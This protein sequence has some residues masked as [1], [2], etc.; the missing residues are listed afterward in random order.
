MIMPGP[1]VF[2]DQYPN[3]TESYGSQGNQCGGKAE[4]GLSPVDGLSAEGQHFY[5]PGAHA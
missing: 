1:P 2:I 5:F 3:K 4:Q